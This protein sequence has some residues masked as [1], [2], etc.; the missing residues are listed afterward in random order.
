M[1]FVDGENLV[2]RA[3]ELM[4]RQ[5]IT[6]QA[7]SHYLKD[8]FVWMP[9]IRPTTP[10]TQPA[11]GL[12][13][14]EF[15]IRSH[16]YA[17]VVGSEQIV[18]KTREALRLLGFQPIVFKRPKNAKQSK[19]VDITLT[20]DMLVHAFN[21]NYDVAVLVSGDGDYVPVVEELKRMGKSVYLLFFEDQ[22]LGLN[23]DLRLACDKFFKLKSMFVGS[24]GGAAAG[25][26]EEY[27]LQQMT[28]GKSATS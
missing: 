26:P 15:S 9:T 25:P 12:K 16:Y 13:L 22:K 8:V 4:G 20:K 2:C 19:G 21:N 11:Q 27:M 17:S 3:Q 10:V 6:L 7:G 23:K 18:S 14:E 24:W 1:M 28:R 5:K